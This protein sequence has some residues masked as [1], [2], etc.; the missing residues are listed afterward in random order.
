MPWLVCVTIADASPSALVFVL[1]LN[2]KITIIDLRLRGRPKMMTIP[3]SSEILH[4][5]EGA[6]MTQGHI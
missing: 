6:W 4:V 3:T 5:A 2:P 1:N